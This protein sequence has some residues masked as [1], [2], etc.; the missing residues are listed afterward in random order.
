MKQLTKLLITLIGLLIIT[1]CGGGSDSSPIGRTAMDPVPGDPYAMLDGTVVITNSVANHGICS[2]IVGSAGNDVTQEVEILITDASKT[3]EFQIQNGFSHG[4][5]S[6]HFDDSTKIVPIKVTV[7]DKLVS[8]ILCD[9]G[10][11][12][13]TF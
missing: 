3:I 2:L 10:Y 6:C 8:D 1:A 7:L 9:F 12:I 13:N 4:I 5:L 11:C